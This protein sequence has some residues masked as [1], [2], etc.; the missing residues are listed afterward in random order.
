MSFWN[1]DYQ[2]KKI[3]VFP[4]AWSS[5]LGS[6]GRD[7]FFSKPTSMLLPLKYKNKLVSLFLTTAY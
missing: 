1:F 7:F 6:V 4:I 3:C 2:A 5:K